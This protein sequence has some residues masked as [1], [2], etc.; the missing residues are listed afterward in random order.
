MFNVL[1]GAQLPATGPNKTV[2]NSSISRHCGRLW[3]PNTP[4]PSFIRCASNTLLLSFAMKPTLEFI[5][6][7]TG[8]DERAL[9]Q[10]IRIHVPTTDNKMHE[11]FLS[12]LKEIRARKLAAAGTQVNAMALGVCASA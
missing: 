5:K 6:L 10:N 2:L 1:Q 9:P 11:R 7:R 3:G 4:G 12:L 8:L